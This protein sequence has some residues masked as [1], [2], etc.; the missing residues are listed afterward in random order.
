[1]RELEVGVSQ[2]FTEIFF[3]SLAPPPSCVPLGLQSC[4]RMGYALMRQ[5]FGGIRGLIIAYVKVS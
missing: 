2:S 5:E 4:V 3:L 1:M